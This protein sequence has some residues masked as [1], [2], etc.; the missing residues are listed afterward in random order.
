MKYVTR[1]KYI[2]ILSANTI[3]MYVNGSNR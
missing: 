2:K 3:L 1:I